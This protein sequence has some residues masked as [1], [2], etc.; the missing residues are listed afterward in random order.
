MIHF[1]KTTRIG[2]LVLLSIISIITL[3]IY[4]CGK[5]ALFVTFV[6]VVGLLVEDIDSE[7]DL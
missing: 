1:F 5:V 6:C 4:V 2:F 3:L 7:E